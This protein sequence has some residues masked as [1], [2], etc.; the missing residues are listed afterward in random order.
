MSLVV[1]VQTVPAPAAAA[2]FAPA[3]APAAAK[4]GDPCTPNSTDVTTAVGLR[5]VNKV[6][7][8]TRGRLKPGP[9]CL[10]GRPAGR[11]YVSRECG[12]NGRGLEYI[13]QARAVAYL[14]EKLEPALVGTGVTPKVQWE[15][16]VGSPSDRAD[17]LY[18][19]PDA[20]TPRMHVIEARSS[21]TGRFAAAPGDVARYVAKL[22]ALPMADV[23]PG[24]ILDN[25]GKYADTFELASGVCRS[26]ARR[27]YSYY[28]AMA[29]NLPG[30]L[31]IDTMRKTRCEDGSKDEQDVGNEGEEAHDP[32][33][34]IPLP[35]N[36]NGDGESEPEAPPNVIPFPQARPLPQPTPLDPAASVADQCSWLC[37]TAEGL[38]ALWALNEAFWTGTDALT[39]VFMN[40]AI[41]HIEANVQFAHDFLR[42][43]AGST[44]GYGDPHLVTVDGRYTSFQ[45]AGEFDLAVSERYDMDIQTRFKPMSN[46]SA[47]DRAAM[48]VNGHRVELTQDGRLLVDG[49]VVDLPENSLLDLHANAAVV[50]TKKGLFTD[51]YYVIWPGAGE[52][53]IFSWQP[54]PGSPR[55]GL[56]FPRSAQSDL[57]GLLGDANGDPADD[58]RLRDG[59]RLPAD[60]SPSTIHG[61]Y[62]DSWRI[63]DATSL[64]TYGPG[65]STGTF[66]DKTFP[67]QIVTVNS[68]TPSEIA[69]GTEVCTTH[70]VAPGP[71][72][73]ACLVDLALT[74]N[75]E[76]AAMAAERQEI[77]VDYSGVR[78]DAQGK[79][80]VDY[81]AAT[82]PNNFYPAQLTRDPAAGSFAGP[83]T[84]R[85]T[86]RFYVQ[87]IPGHVTGTLSFDVVAV[88][89]WAA[90][91]SAETMALQV[92]RTEVWRKTVDAST[93]PVRTG[94]LANGKPYAVYRFQVPLTH[95]ASQLEAVFSA[96]GVDGLAGEGFGIDNVSLAFPVIAPQ[97]FDVTLP[98]SVSNGSPGTGAGNL[99]TP[100]S[101]DEYRF[102]VAAGQSVFVDVQS[103]PATY[104]LSWQIVAADGRTVGSYACGDDE[105]E[106]LPAGTYR[107]V[108]TPMFD[109]TGTYSL[110]V[111][112]VPAAQVFDVSLPLS[113]AENVPGPGAG[114]LE[115]K[116]SRDEFRFTVA[117]GQSI[118]VDPVTCPTSS[119]LSY[120]SWELIGPTGATVLSRMLCSDEQ[121]DNLP[122]GTY[123]LVV[124]P[125]SGLI[126]K[127]T[128]QAFV[129]PAPQVFDV[130]LPV[131]I[132]NGVPAVG[133][134]NLETKASRDEYRL[135]LASAG[136]IDVNPQTCPSGGAYTG[137]NWQV[138][139]SAGTTVDTG[140]CG[141]ERTVPLAP[142]AYRFV[143]SPAYGLTGAYKIGLTAVP[144]PQVF[145]VT[146]PAAVSNGVPAAGAGNLETTLSQDEYRFSV[147]AGQSVYVD[148]QNCVGGY[149]LAWSLVDAAGRSVNSGACSDLQVDGL[150][151]GTYRLVVTPMWD[152]TG[153]YSL[154][155]FV[156]PAPQVFDVS[157]PL[158]VSTNVPGPGAGVLETKASRDEFRFTVAAGQSIYVDPQTCP[159][160]S[161]LDYLDW[162][163]VGPTGATVK[164]SSLCSDGQAD[165]LPAGTYR[166][167]VTPGSGVTGA[168]TLH[169]FVVPAPQ[170]FD[171]ALPVTISNGV[172]AVGA[173]NLETKASRD[174]YRFTLTTAKA[175]NVDVQSCP[176]QSVYTGLNW[177]VVD[178]AGT[179]LKSGTCSDDRT[180]SLAPGTYRLVVTPYLNLTG[181]YRIALATV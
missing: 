161:V 129:V 1:G 146:L 130:A 81:E 115:T 150:A 68:L 166:L 122:A 141:H 47:F 155:L 120:L 149:Y 85:G 62:A 101:V 127:Y 6:L 105:V 53:P 145:D 15:V 125:D 74:D 121:I 56:Y 175:V 154:E 2:A 83:Y 45:S 113:V 117:A 173:G 61:A 142:G 137:L 88:G 17:I 22:K 176:S 16:E 59:T 14:N 94:T 108:V 152:R 148:I 169:A 123:R 79:L 41:S 86:Y 92:D 84:G 153:T 106:N 172:P 82:V 49:A 102:T 138:V 55:V 44:N 165:N 98:F 70:G 78:P 73:D 13:A 48:E 164:S 42:A 38:A 30:V 100:V 156:V 28:A 171:V 168:Y 7:L 144:A 163:V 167:V 35:G 71:Q 20:A 25:W 170:V 77:A 10:L 37:V 124:S 60:T 119:P 51:T 158:S 66:T 159:T 63:T 64:F 133:A 43:L 104:Y 23:V 26:G 80:T 72:F 46:W 21:A 58:L 135:T 99:E 12:G 69:L 90:D 103:C 29:P 160:S 116:A 97:R 110:S 8:R 132:S 89:D 118:Y 112:A 65:E 128:L 140:F 40:L 111:F 54:G 136:T 87:T 67:H 33:H 134:G 32:P 95:S 114:V 36:T 93:P 39:R 177:Q 151:A 11:I 109:R 34:V 147:T 27:I 162:K 139:N 18:Y 131:T 52:R 9:T 180:A 19:E 181:P 5:C 57:R 50:H 174:E 178:S 75:N 91:G 126:G 143:V 157:L 4:P 179:V 24:T 96:S 107:L 3:A 76:F 31:Q